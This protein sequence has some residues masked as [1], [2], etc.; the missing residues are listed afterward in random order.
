MPKFETQVLINRPVFHVFRYV[1]DFNNDV[2]WRNVRGVGMT[3]G[4]PIRAGTMVAM[5]RRIMGRSGFVNSDV[6]D[7]ERNKKIEL[8][9]SYWGFP[10]VSTITFEHRGQQTNVRETL[11]I[12]TRWFFWF[13]I[14]F[15]LTLKGVLQR[16]W[17]KLKQLMDAHG[18]RRS[19][20]P[21]PIPE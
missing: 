20:T 19:A 16:E 7:F 8:K 17:N 11:D 3:S 21:Q 1:G 15:N 18:D 13:G 10:F 4:D 6:T 14:F 12:R 5:T 2:H 9:G